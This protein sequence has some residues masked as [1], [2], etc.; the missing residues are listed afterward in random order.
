[1]PDSAD[2]ARAREAAA[3]GEVEARAR[4]LA[5]ELRRG[6]RSPGELQLLAYLADP[7][8]CLA[9]GEDPPALP[10]DDQDAAVLWLRGFA[11]W[12]DEVLG[13]AVVAWLWSWHDLEAPGSTFSEVVEAWWD[14][15]AAPTNL[16]LAARAQSEGWV[17]NAYA[18]TRAVECVE[19][20][21]RRS[22]LRMAEG[23]L[24]PRPRHLPAP[25]LILPRLGGW[26]GVARH[27]LAP[28]VVGERSLVQ[29]AIDG[30]TPPSRRALVAYLRANPRAR[31]L[32]G[33]AA[34]V[35]VLIVEEVGFEDVG[36]FIDGSPM[37][38]IH[39]DLLAIP[40]GEGESPGA[41]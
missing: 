11:A 1:M 21:D 16:E 4:V 23:Q 22:L 6:A 32:Y 35:C 27:A 30:G 40:P 5:D 10:A 29:R 33:N 3:T 14:G 20:A 13:R 15:R 8:A 34:E 9:L 12:G 37:L 41:R 17:G 36:G 18:V 31:V 26:I 7:A 2:R 25:A 38:S 24:H 28:V 19:R 39:L